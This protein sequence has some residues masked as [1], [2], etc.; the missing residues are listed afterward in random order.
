MAKCAGCDR[1][2][3]FD[4]NCVETGDGD[5]CPECAAQYRAEAEEEICYQRQDNITEQ[6]FWGYKNGDVYAV[7][8]NYA[9]AVTGVCGPIHR[10]EQ[11]IGSLPDFDYSAEDTDWVNENVVDFQL[12]EGKMI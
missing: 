6:Q 7:E 9:G 8:I 2:F 12:I 1:N 3:I 11:R 10:S 4:E 5:L